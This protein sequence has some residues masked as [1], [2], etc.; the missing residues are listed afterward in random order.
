VFFLFVFIYYLLIC[1]CLILVLLTLFP[2]R[3]NADVIIFPLIKP[4]VLEL[5][6]P[7][8]QY[9][10]TLL[11][12]PTDCTQKRDQ[13]S[14]TLQERDTVQANSTLCSLLFFHSNI[15]SFTAKPTDRGYSEE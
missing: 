2:I 14:L 3:Y 6:H 13:F 1:T 9:M 11:T 7:V 5:P 12:V 4:T 15:G 8:S 10:S